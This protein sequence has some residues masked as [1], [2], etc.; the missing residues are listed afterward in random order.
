MP[1]LMLQ[2]QIRASIVTLTIK[3]EWYN[4]NIRKL[5]V[6]YR[7]IT[8]IGHPRVTLRMGLYGKK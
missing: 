5:I 2:I 1:I 6:I 3:Q 8:E 4:S 7:V